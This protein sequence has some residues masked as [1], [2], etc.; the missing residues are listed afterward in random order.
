MKNYLLLTASAVLVLSSCS[1]NEIIEK[2]DVKNGE[3]TKMSISAYV[4]GMT[5]GYT[6]ED[7]PEADM[8]SLKEHGFFLLTSINLGDDDYLQGHMRFDNNNSVDGVWT[9]QDVSEEYVYWPSDPNE[10]VNFYA[11]YSSTGMTAED[12]VESADDGMILNVST[13]DGKED[14]MAADTALSL[15][16]TPT[17]V[18]DLTFEHILAQVVVRIVGT[19]EN[20]EYHVGGVQLKAPKSSQYKFSTNSFLIDEEEDPKTFDLDD[21]GIT[22]LGT[23][24]DVDNTGLPK[25]NTVPSVDDEE[26]N[27]GEVLV[28]PGACSLSFYYETT[29]GSNT[30]KLVSVGNNDGDKK[31][32]FTALKGYRNI[33]TVRIDPITKAMTFSVSLVGWQDNA[34]QD[35]D[36]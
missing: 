29:V 19:D 18:V 1:N 11:A 6:F 22:A 34:S 28:V 23:E 4:P 12:I 33:V 15:S 26:T 31:I 32:E 14:Y 9:L 3:A 30:G 17:G 27:Y 35:F 25:Y 7:A 8:D 10:D 21:I 16:K 5:R 20:Y 13:A 24:F 36:L 2:K